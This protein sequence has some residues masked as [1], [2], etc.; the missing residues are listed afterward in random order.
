MHLAMLPLV[1]NCKYQ[2]TQ[3][4]FGIYNWK[5]LKIASMVFH[6]KY[7]KHIGFCYFQ[8]F[9]IE[10]TKKHIGLFYFQWFSIVDTKKTHIGFLLFS[11]VFN[12]K[13]QKPV[14]FLLFSIVFYCKHQKPIGFLLFSMVLYCKY[15]GS[16]LRARQ[17]NACSTTKCIIQAWENAFARFPDYR[18]VYGSW[19]PKT[20]KPKPKIESRLVPGDW[21]Q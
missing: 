18:L 19:Q 12:C 2:N 11:M 13:H 21:P 8:W 10:N 7:Q 5:P 15:Q 17:N 9:S 6:W 1:F 4:F 20:T 16:R 14:G 3:R